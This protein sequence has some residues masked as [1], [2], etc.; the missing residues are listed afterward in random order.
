MSSHQTS[1]ITRSVRR[2]IASDLQ[3][4]AVVPPVYLSSM[5]AYENL[6]RKRVHDYTRDSNPTRGDLEA[7]LADLEGG[8]GAVV[9]SSGTSAL[10][11]ALQLVEPRG[12][13]VAPFD[14]YGGTRRLLTAL[15]QRGHFEVDFRD[16]TAT[17]PLEDLPRAPA[18]VWVETPSNPLLRI[19]DIRKLAAEAHAQGALVIAD[20][21][22]L[23]PALQQPLSLGVDVVVH[24]TT[25]YLNGHSDVVGG[26][27]VAADE[28]VLQKLQFWAR[29]LGITGAP[30]D[31][32]LTL[33]GLRTLFPRMAA[34]VR[35]AQAV[36]IALSSHEAVERVY[37]PGLPSHPG[38]EIAALQQSAFGAL[39]SFELRGGAESVRCFVEH[40]HCFTLAKSLGGV[41][42]LIAHPAT[43][44]HAHMPPEMRAATGI[45]DSLV[46]LSVGIESIVDLVHDL[47]QAL[48]QVLRVADK[49]TRGSLHTEVG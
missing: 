4:G 42:S 6:D 43:M 10:L 5:F 46:R 28:D 25:K 2:G 12:L 49:E 11:L 36:A 40:L 31:S 17:Q 26:C 22:V 18:V 32:Y 41:E 20:N 9:T 47:R 8:R 15:A 3:H 29:C 19:T 30:F 16:L 24:S 34:H 37:Y 45:T 44:S 13:V 38:H 14:C 33:R 23:S 39:L 35:N 7:A 21:T 1:P 27:V 48:D